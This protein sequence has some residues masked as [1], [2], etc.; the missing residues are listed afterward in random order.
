MSDPLCQHPGM[1]KTKSI[2]RGRGQVNSPAGI[3]INDFDQLMAAGETVEHTTVPGFLR[4]IEHPWHIDDLT[5]FGDKVGRVAEAMQLS[6]LTTIQ[7]QL[8]MIRVFPLPLLQRVY[9]LMAPQFQW[10]AEPLVLLEGRRALREDLRK[11]E[12][13]AQDLSSIAESVDNVEVLTAVQTVRD[14]LTT[15]I[16]RLKQEIG[17]PA[18]AT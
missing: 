6:Y 10:P 9:E 18:S 1:R 11:H 5:R 17:T 8:G 16:A 15:D 12:R 3:D 7:P 13:A 14:F 2:T 4:R